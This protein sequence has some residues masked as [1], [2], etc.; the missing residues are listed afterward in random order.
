MLDICRDKATEFMRMAEEALA[1]QALKDSLRVKRGTRQA[2][3]VIEAYDSGELRWRRMDSDDDT[4]MMMMP[5]GCEIPICQQLKSYLVGSSDLDEAPLSRGLNQV[6]CFRRDDKRWYVGDETYDEDSD[7]QAIFVPLQGPSRDGKRIVVYTY[8]SE[9]S[10]QRAILAAIEL[11]EIERL[12][13]RLVGDVNARIDKKLRV[14]ARDGE[15]S[16]LFEAFSPPT[17]IDDSCQRITTP[18]TAAR[19]RPRID[20]LQTADVG[21]KQKLRVEP[22]TEIQLTQNRV[23]SE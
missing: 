3:A 19:V 13:D 15:A 18:K 22:L 23:D 17:R 2:K 10:A 20:D 12:D 7:S 4:A 11:R 14:W 8:P 5:D 6:V 16:E 9:D 21:A 1:V